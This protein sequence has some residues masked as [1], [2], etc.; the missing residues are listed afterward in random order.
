ML[1]FCDGVRMEP[2]FTFNTPLDALSFAIF[3]VHGT[4]IATGDRIGA[5]QGL[6]SAR[7]QILGTLTLAGEPL[8]VAQIA[9]LM[10]L[11][12]QAVQRVT[13]DLEQAGMLTMRDNPA[14]KRARLAWPTNQGRAAYAAVMTEWAHLAAILAV[15]LPDT[16]IA[17]T[18]ACLET[19]K[20]ELQTLSPSD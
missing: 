18:I 13:N 1:S 6:T 7:W 3:R 20:D 10:G 11:T 12:R 8:T 15:N 4:L 14:H 17:E 9:R 19:L 5:A 16:R 2:K